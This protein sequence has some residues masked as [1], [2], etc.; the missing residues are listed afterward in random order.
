MVA[1]DCF[2]ILDKIQFGLG[3]VCFALSFNNL[4]ETFIPRDEHFVISLTVDCD[5]THF[6]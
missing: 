2:Q 1:L 5:R 3:M 6:T 4:L